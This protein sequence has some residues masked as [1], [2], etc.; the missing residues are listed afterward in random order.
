MPFVQE[1]IITWQVSFGDDGA[2]LYVDGLIADAK[3]W[4]DQD[5]SLN[6]NSLVIGASTTW[7]NEEYDHLNS[8]FEGTDFNV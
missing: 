3:V 8:P 5:I 2:R 4:F 7:R 1:K 6:Q